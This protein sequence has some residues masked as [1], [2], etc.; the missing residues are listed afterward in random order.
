[1]SEYLYV[2][3]FLAV[4]LAALVAAAVLT[5]LVVCVVVAAARWAVWRLRAPF[6]RHADQ[7]MALTRPTWV[8]RVID[9]YERELADCYLTPGE[10]F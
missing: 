10:D 5:A 6:E 3:G 2:A 4:I 7:A 9:E 8:D 1:M